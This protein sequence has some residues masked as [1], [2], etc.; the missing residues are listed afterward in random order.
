MIPLKSIPFQRGSLRCHHE[1]KN[2]DMSPITSQLLDLH[3][4]RTFHRW[5]LGHTKD[6][7]VPTHRQSHKG[8]WKTHFTYVRITKEEIPVGVVN[9]IS[10]PFH[11]WTDFLLRNCRQYSAFSALNH[12]LMVTRTTKLFHWLDN[13]FL[14]LLQILNKKHVFII[15]VDKSL[16]MMCIVEIICNTHI[17]SIIFTTA[18]FNV[19]LNSVDNSKVTVLSTKTSLFILTNL[20]NGTI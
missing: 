4:T 7:G 3:I 14:G 13:Y 9:S 15:C 2:Y 5:L 11:I 20:F 17:W 6:T 12:L 18:Q 19:K 8:W 1:K 10:Q 16:K